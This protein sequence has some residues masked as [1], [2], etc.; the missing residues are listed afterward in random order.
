MSL[1]VDSRAEM[2]VRIL[3][4]APMLK[5]GLT[6]KINPSTIDRLRRLFVAPLL[7]FPTFAFPSVPAFA[8]N[9]TSASAAQIEGTVRDVAGAP[10]A[11]VTLRLQEAGSSDVMDTKTSS[12]GTFAFSSVRSGI[13]GLKLHKPG[14]E[15]A[16][17]ESIQL[18]PAEKK[19][20]D[21]VLRPAATAAPLPSA[22]GGIQLDDRPTFTV[23][24]VTDST[25]SGGHGSETRMRTGEALA[26]ETVHLE[27][28][29]VKGSETTGTSIPP[30]ESE[31]VLR[32]AVAKSPRSFEANHR[33]GAFYFRADRCREAIPPLEAA[34]QSNPENYEN[35]FDLASALKS[36]GEFAQSRD[37]VDQIL[38][39][40]K[41][42]S[43]PQAADLH[44][45]LA[46][47]DEKLE[48]PLGAEREYERAADLDAS[49]QNY[50]AWGS[51]L[52]L[53]RA[54]APAIEVFG[55]GARLHPKS[56]RMLAGLGAA[57]YTSGSAEDAAHRLCDASDVDP[58]DSAP[59]LFLGKMQEATSAA[60]PCAE[61]KLARFAHDQPE[62]AL[63]NYY[64]GLA[65]WRRDRG[66]KDSETLQRAKVLLKKA[67]ALDPK[68]DAAFLELGNLNFALG[69][70]PEAV[71]S[72]EKAIAA[73]PT[74]SQAHYRLGLTYKRLGDEAKAQNE[75][76]QYK[77]LD[78]TES[79]NIERQRRELRQ[80]LFVLKDQPAASRPAPDA[81]PPS[82]N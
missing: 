76:A 66:S 27:S 42:L 68:L 29:P 22:A 59:Y 4:R 77:K 71:A 11:G 39:K 65:L 20:C 32:A 18:A 63:A 69:A 61:Q 56:S 34:D 45:L 49:E 55:K 50:F 13:Y 52:L 72:Y 79:A 5:R 19:H 46:E 62:N 74:S 81:P 78:Q 57:L 53:H 28:S 14:F 12:E 54:A 67:T 36:C 35:V 64:Y 58:A 16:V 37:R 21:F 23:A 43:A 7:L 8:Q 75:F 38:A 48:D 41:Q 6:G 24:G 1:T 10:V 80:F 33:L 25:G 60:L 9:V 82:Q 73:N 26:K 15:D 3:N 40:D 2:M 51:E 44:R 31:N 17:E 70:F 30:T 47:V